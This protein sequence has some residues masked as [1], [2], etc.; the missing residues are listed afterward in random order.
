MSV[1]NDAYLHIVALLT[2]HEEQDTQMMV[3]AIQGVLQDP[4][5][6]VRGLVLTKLAET[7]YEHVMENAPPGLTYKALVKQL[8]EEGILDEGKDEDGT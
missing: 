2:A 8:F 4:N 7:V 1:N 6:V 3:V 5:Y